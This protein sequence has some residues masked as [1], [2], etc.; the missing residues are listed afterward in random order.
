M[1]GNSRPLRR[2]IFRIVGVLLILL[3]IV[4]LDSMG[5]SRLFVLL[6]G[7]AIGLEEPLSVW[8][9]QRQLRT[10]SNP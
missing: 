2:R 3:C 9:I 6:T 8:F 10:C 4:F 7:D 5:F 1:Q